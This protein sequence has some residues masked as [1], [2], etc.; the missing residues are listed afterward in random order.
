MK[1]GLEILIQLSDS[2]N[3]YESK[4]KRGVANGNESLVLVTFYVFTGHRIDGIML[5]LHGRL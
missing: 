1:K 5:S 3:K 2:E 4:L